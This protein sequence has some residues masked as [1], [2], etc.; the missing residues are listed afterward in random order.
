MTPEGAPRVDLAGLTAYFAGQADVIAAY[1]FGSTARGQAGRLSDVDIAV[2]LDS[3]VDGEAALER[4]LKLMIDMDNFADREVQILILNRAVPL[5]AYQVIRD[6]RLL[7]ERNRADRVAFEVRA[8]K[9]YFDLQPML[10][11][12]NR[13]LL[14]R[15]REVGLGKGRHGD[16]GALGAARRIYD[17]LATAPER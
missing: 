6:G 9:L 14:T 2:L 1:L 5:L 8:M 3:L 4:Q 7:F 12:Q 15:I 16:S 13:A 17:R 10:A 11:V